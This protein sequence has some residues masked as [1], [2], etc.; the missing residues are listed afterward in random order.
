MGGFQLFERN[1]QPLQPMDGANDVAPHLIEPG[2]FIRKLDIED[3]DH[4]K[5]EMIVPYV[6]EEEIKDR[7]KSDAIAKGIV[8]LQ[9]MWFIIQCAARGL[10][11]LPLT[12]L[13][14]MTLAYAMMNF[15]IYIFW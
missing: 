14:V 2:T 13:E 15:F 12:R 4:Y 1:A 11:H 10:T 9:T 5:L 7:G 6:T 8:L 3:V